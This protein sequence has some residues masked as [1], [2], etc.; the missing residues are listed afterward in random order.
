M[1]SEIEYDPDVKEDV[2]IDDERFFLKMNDGN[3]VY[4]NTPN[5]NKLNKYKEAIASVYDQTPGILSLDSNSNNTLFKKYDKIED[6]P[7]E[8]QVVEESD[9]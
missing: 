7:E 5:M 9:E 3:S 4:I 6:I 8:E 2:V 1:V